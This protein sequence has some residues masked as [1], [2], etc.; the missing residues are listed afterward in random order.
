MLKEV[1]NDE[2]SAASQYALKALDKM[3][4]LS[5]Q[6]LSTELY[7]ILNAKNLHG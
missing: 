4:K 5:I 6:V 1:L 3:K 2:S 7:L